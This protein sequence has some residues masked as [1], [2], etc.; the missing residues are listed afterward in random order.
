MYGP[1]FFKGAHYMYIYHRNE[2]SDGVER[3]KDL[4]NIA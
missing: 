3:T 1:D 2:P 4:L